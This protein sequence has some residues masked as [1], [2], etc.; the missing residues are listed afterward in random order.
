[1]TDNVAG[2]PPTAAHMTGTLG[3]SVTLQH[4]ELGT[5][6]K[7]SCGQVVVPLETCLAVLAARCADAEARAAQLDQQLFTIE[8]DNEILAQQ[9]DQALS[10]LPEGDPIGDEHRAK[11]REA[12]QKRDDQLHEANV[13]LSQVV[14]AL[15]PL[16]EQLED[17]VTVVVTHTNTHG[18]DIAEAM[19]S[20]DGYVENHID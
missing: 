1:M 17:G 14:D 20:I 16:T 3:S 5:M 19:A 18:R 4:P 7:L 2:R 10:R 8:A 6:F 13:T 9:R 11:V 12:Q 15:A